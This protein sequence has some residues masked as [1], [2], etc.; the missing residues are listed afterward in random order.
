MGQRGG[1]VSSRRGVGVVPV[2]IKK[3]SEFIVDTVTHFSAKIRSWFRALVDCLTT[4]S[5]ALLP[6]L[7]VPFVIEIG[8]CDCRSRRQRR[9]C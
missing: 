3:L 9:K 1:G 2:I 4:L 7:H 5:V 6:L 8:A